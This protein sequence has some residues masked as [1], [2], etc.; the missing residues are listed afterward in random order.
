[1]GA[2]K[3][4]L[5]HTPISRS[6]RKRQTGDWSFL[7]QLKEKFGDDKSLATL[8]AALEEVKHEEV[9]YDKEYIA[10]AM[11]W[12]TPESAPPEVPRTEETHAGSRTT[13]TS[14]PLPGERPLHSYMGSGD[15]KLMQKQSFPRH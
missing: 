2:L 1:M 6:S 15:H 4:H 3:T 11:G 10:T 8:R 5:P 7:L 13:P 12:V 9:A 14:P